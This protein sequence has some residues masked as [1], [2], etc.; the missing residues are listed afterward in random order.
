MKPCTPII[1][2]P[3]EDM[4]AVLYTRRYLWDFMYFINIGLGPQIYSIQYIK[5]PLSPS[6]CIEHQQSHTDTH[7]QCSNAL[8]NTIFWCLEMSTSDPIGCCTFYGSHFCEPRELW[9]DGPSC[10]DV[11]HCLEQWC[12]VSRGYGEREMEH[13]SL[14]SFDSK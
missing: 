3:C 10:F 9:D 13:P 2:F 8:L 5:A 1:S 7:P 11:P 6:H 4:L 12:S 14:S